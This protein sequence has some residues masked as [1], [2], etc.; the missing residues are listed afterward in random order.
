[1]RS[2]NRGQTSWRS[3]NYIVW[4]KRPGHKISF[5]KSHKIFLD[6]NR[7]GIYPSWTNFAQY[8]LPNFADY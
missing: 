8:L 6:E 7:K 2:R 3:K 1:M 4:V 5:L